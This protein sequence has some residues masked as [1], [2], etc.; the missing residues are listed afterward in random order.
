MLQSCEREP[1]T[2]NDKNNNEKFQNITN[3]SASDK[4]NNLFHQTSVSSSTSQSI[5]QRENPH[6]YLLYKPSFSQFFAY[7]SAA[8]KDLP[9]M[10]VLMLYISA[11]G[12][13]SSSKI[14]IDRN[15]Y[16]KIF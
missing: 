12:F 1:S 8:F 11:D 9:P 13:E 16:F 6:K 4:S 10:G 5:V 14:Q 3:T 2:L 15:K 7:I